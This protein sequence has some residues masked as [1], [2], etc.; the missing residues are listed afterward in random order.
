[1]QRHPYPITPDALYLKGDSEN[2][3]SE[4]PNQHVALREHPYD[5]NYVLRHVRRVYLQVGRMGWEWGEV[6]GGGG[7]G[8]ER[9]SMYLGIRYLLLNRY[10]STAYA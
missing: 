1:V 3:A 7:G 5:L 10:T 6:G 2:I 4:L 9:V 8:G